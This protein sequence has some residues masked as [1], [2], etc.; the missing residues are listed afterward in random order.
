MRNISDS[1]QYYT[2]YALIF[3]NRLKSWNNVHIT[4]LD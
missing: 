4:R 2:D 1:K 3:I